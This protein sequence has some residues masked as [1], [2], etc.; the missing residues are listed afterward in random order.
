MASE[1]PIIV[2]ENTPMADIVKKEEC[3]LIIPYKNEIALGKAINLIKNDKKLQKS[4]GYNGKKAYQNKYSWTIMEKRLLSI[5]DHVL[6]VNMA[7]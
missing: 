4:M 2:N 5:Y 7:E 6:N 3:G 1:I